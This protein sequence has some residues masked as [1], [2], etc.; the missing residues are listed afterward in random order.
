MVES[1]T[2]DQIEQYTGENLSAKEP[3]VLLGTVLKCPDGWQERSLAEMA[4][5]SSNT[6]N[7]PRKRKVKRNLLVEILELL[8]EYDEPLTTKEMA[9]I[10]G[11]NRRYVSQ[12]ISKSRA[13][14]GHNIIFRVGKKT[15]EG[16]HYILRSKHT[17]AQNR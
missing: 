2:V 14:H 1:L 17:L 9:L 13:T 8:K 16:Y 6:L 5:F 4:T 15:K 10:L 7:K 11:A 12:A 3:V